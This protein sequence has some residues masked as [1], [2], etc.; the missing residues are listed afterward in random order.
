MAIPFTFNEMQYKIKVT[1][2][3]TRKKNN[4]YCCANKRICRAR[5]QIAQMADEQT[6]NWSG[7]IWYGILEIRYG[8]HAKVR[9]GSRRF[10]R[11]PTI[12]S[13]THAQPARW[14]VLAKW[15]IKANIPKSNYTLGT[16]ISELNKQPKKGARIVTHNAH[17]DTHL[18]WPDAEYWAK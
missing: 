15:G 2:E 9:L 1:L 6:V 4:P 16:A 14:L 7:F 12:I 13:L 10:Y 18:K 3:Y 5:V 17:T 8:T 11:Y